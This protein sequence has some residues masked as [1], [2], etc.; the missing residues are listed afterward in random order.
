MLRIIPILTLPS[1]LRAL[2]LLRS[3]D[4]DVWTTSDRVVV[5]SSL[6]EKVVT[7][8]NSNPTPFPDTDL[9]NPDRIL[10]DLFAH[11]QG[12]Q[13]REAQARAREGLRGEE[14]Q[15]RLLLYR[16]RAAGKPY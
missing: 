14:G 9:T 12:V 8:P 7:N 1:T 6:I 15:A 11:K 5:M 13:L 3:S 16:R 2:Q 10:T 4:P